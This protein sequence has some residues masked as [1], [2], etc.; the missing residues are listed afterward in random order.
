MAFPMRLIGLHNH[1]VTI[2][3]ISYLNKNVVIYVV[4]KVMFWHNVVFIEDKGKV[5]A[6]IDLL[7]QDQHD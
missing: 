1:V 3:H 5:N 6:N 7:Q 4:I 2:N